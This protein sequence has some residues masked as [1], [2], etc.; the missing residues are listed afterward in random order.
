MGG[1]LKCIWSYNDGEYRGPF[2]KFCNI[3]GIRLEKIVPKTSQQN[4]V[5][6]IM[7]RTIV[8]R[9]RCI[10]SHAKLPKLFWGEAMRTAVNLI[11][12]SPSVPLDGNILER[13]WI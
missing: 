7:N 13:V 1:Q 2:E 6:E 11:N 4:G 10:L 9:I 8:E 3:H 5:A 12:F